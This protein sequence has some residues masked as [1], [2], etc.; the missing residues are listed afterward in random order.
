[1]S[2][3]NKYFI[4][5][6]IPYLYELKQSTI[7]NKLSWVEIKP[8]YLIPKDQMERFSEIKLKPSTT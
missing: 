3:D 2:Q 8:V 7:L 1:M 5:T 4:F 6:D